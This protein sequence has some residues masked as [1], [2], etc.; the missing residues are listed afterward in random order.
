MP[1]I[2]YIYVLVAFAIVHSRL[3]K[4]ETETSVGDSTNYLQLQ[5]LSYKPVLHH[6]QYNI[7]NQNFPTARFPLTRWRAVLFPCAHYVN[8]ERHLCDKCRQCQSADYQKHATFLLSVQHPQGLLSLHFLL[9]F[10]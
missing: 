6:N 9:H 10:I 7:I 1:L 3:L 8:T 4:S 2:T 5:S